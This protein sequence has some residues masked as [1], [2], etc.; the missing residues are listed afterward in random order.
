MTAQWYVLHSKPLKEALLWEQLSLQNIESYY[1]CIRVQPINV[2]A[3]RVK[4][5]FPGYIFGHVDL[6]QTNLS[7]LQW[8]PGA[9]GMVSFGGVPSSVPDHIIAA[10]RHRVDEIN[11]AGGELL[12]DL[13]PG[14][15]VTIREGPFS[16][17]DAIFDT[18]LSGEERVRVLLKLLNARKFPLELPVSQIQRKNGNYH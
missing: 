1:P 4:P 5:Y 14:D 16:G 18:R 2:H 11:A 7:T 15:I 3:R 6:E 12:R 8:M 9:A 10:I 13:K 17:Y